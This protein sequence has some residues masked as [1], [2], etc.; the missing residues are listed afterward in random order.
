MTLSIVAKSDCEVFALVQ[1]LSTAKSE[2]SAIGT[3]IVGDR[4]ILSA[5]TKQCVALICVMVNQYA[6]QEAF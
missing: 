5:C 6:K 1:E 2:T 4:Q 3:L